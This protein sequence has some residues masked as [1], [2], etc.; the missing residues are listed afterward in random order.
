MN[1]REKLGRLSAPLPRTAAAAAVHDVAPSPL[2]AAESVA[3]AEHPESDAQ[4]AERIAKLRSLIG[5]V[6]K[7]GEA[8]NKPRSAPA[9]HPRFSDVLR[10]RRRS[11]ELRAS[12]LASPAA[13]PAP[14]FAPPPVRERP[15]LPWPTEDTPHG[16]VHVVE[17]YL[18]PQ[19]A[20][21]KISVQSALDR[22][23]ATVAALALDP[24][25]AGLDLSRM[26]FLDTETTGLA[27]GTGSVAFLVGLA[28]FDDRS[29]RLT[30]LLVVNLGG[31]AP[32]L[33]VLAARLAAASC[34][35]TYNGKS[36]DWPLLRTRFVMNRLPVPELP[37]HVDLLHAS[38]RIWKARLGS[39]RLTDVEREIMR[40]FRADDIDGS[41][42]PSRYFSFLRDGGSE[43][44]VPVLEH[45]QN[46]LIALPAMLGTLGERFEQIECGEQ[47]LDALAFGKLA[48]RLDDSE[49]AQAFARAAVRVSEGGS[50][51]S[52][53][54]SFS[55][56]VE[57]RAGDAAAAV[58]HFERAL[59]VCVMPALRA[60][61]HAVLARLYEHRLRDLPRAY[62]HARHTEPCEGPELHARRLGRLT[63]KLLRQAARS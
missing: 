23:P 34:I 25:C 24:A 38:R 27:G 19:H 8:W 32:M 52:Q 41:E 21:G 33:S 36:F 40:F 16:P 1:I 6:L 62:R 18:E 35:L 61:L 43:W 55:G 12:L 63:R 46:D 15:P 10:E 39:V 50:L 60:E 57:R 53:A 17:R 56:E 28:Q 30:Q 7:R 9:A 22:L 11:H 47:A 3:A 20:H 51:E 48:L 13:R 44:L 42:I 45:N 37:P 2:M 49:R 14:A 5:D 31:E 54:W 29:L 58:E 4:R 59:A 26:L